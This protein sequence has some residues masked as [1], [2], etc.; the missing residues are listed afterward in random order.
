MESGDKKNT[1]NL[2]YETALVFKFSPGRKT[3][4]VGGDPSQSFSNDVNI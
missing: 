1:A 4:I 3:K 2:I